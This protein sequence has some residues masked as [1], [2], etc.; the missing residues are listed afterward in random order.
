MSSSKELETFTD[1]SIRI[2]AKKILS[3]RNN[4]DRYEKIKRIGEGTYGVVCKL[5]EHILI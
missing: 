5:K 3:K 1:Q 2:N 4:V